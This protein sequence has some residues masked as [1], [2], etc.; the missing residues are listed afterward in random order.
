[1]TTKKYQRLFISA[2]LFNWAVAAIFFLAYK[3]FF[4]LIGLTPVPAHPIYLHLFACL[5]AVFG[6]AYFWISQDVAENR[7][8]VTLGIIGK[9]SVFAMPLAYFLAGSISWQLPALASADLIYAMLFANALRQ[10]P[11]SDTIKIS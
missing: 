9:L 10:L 11:C 3:P 1:M 7:N 8:L 6:I 4:N 5:V 2:A